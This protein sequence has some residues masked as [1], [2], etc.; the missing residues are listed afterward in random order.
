MSTIEEEETVEAHHTT[1]QESIMSGESVRDGVNDIQRVAHY[2]R[3]VMSSIED[4]GVNDNT[5]NHDDS[6]DSPP[7]SF[8][9][10][11]LPRTT[12]VLP[13]TTRARRHARHPAWLD[14]VLAD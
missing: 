13:L 9:T 12:D 8:P 11:G 6:D 3:Q 5:L 10:T 1:P 4:D 7:L 2:R 14:D